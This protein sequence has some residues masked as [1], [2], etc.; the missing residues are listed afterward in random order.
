[1]RHVVKES[2]LDVER[3]GDAWRV[4]GRR[5]ER[6]VATTDMESEEAVELLQRRLIGMGV[7]RML[8]AAGAVRGDEV[9]IGDTAFDFEPE[10]P[11]GEGDPERVQT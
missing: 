11:V 3:E 7:E 9:R 10:A 5:A 1:M 8:A 2:P 6:A 4:R